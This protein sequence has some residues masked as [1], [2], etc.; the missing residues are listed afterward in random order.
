[1]SG[2]AGAVR[3][4]LTGVCRRNGGEFA[5]WVGEMGAELIFAQNCT[6]SYIAE[7]R[8][9]MDRSRSELS[10]VLFLDEAGRACTGATAN[11]RSSFAKSSTRRRSLPSREKDT[12]TPRTSSTLFGKEVSYDVFGGRWALLML[13]SVLLNQFHDVLPGSAIGMVYLDAE[14]VRSSTMLV[15]E[16]S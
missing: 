6:S 11:L 12:S 1:M 3:I 10:V 8:R 7:R 4:G 16:R 2:F 5:G 14:K 13:A 9:V 15:W